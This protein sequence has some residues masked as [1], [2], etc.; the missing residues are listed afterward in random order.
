MFQ[1][2]SVGRSVI[3][4]LTA[5]L[6]LL[7]AAC[8]VL[9]GKF[10]AT[11]DIR[12]DGHFTYTYQ[13]EV[14]VL[15]LT[16][17]A[18]IAMSDKLAKPFEAA[19]CYKNDSET[20]RP[21]TKP[22]L[23]K[24]KTDW[25][26]AQAAEKKSQQ[27]ELATFKRAFGGIDPNDPKAAEDLA[28]RLRQQAGWNSV[29]YQGNGKY[30]VDFSITGTLDRDFAFPSIERMPAILPFQVINRRANGEVRIDSP[31]M[32]G[33]PLGLGGGALAQMYAQ[34]KATD[35]NKPWPEFP[36]T[37]GHF[38]LTTDGVILSNNTEH[39]PTAVRRGKQ[40]E[41]DISGHNPIAPMALIVLTK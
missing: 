32:Q 8:L 33:A 3:A 36:Q 35:D 39:G 38:T 31:I 14:L 10:A 15:G 2:I 24:Q 5:G 16:R 28:M 29:T 20:E 13:G 25:E 18:Q 41:W 11:L 27:D 19:A 22:E 23:D 12:K 7:L 1:S 26:I 30:L 37:E 6:A 9:P 21:C 17:L 40:L 4:A 34:S